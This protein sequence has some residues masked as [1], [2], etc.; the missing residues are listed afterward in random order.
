MLSDLRS[1]NLQLA[2]ISNSDDRLPKVLDQKQ[3]TQYFDLIVTS[4]EC[5]FEKPDKRI[6]EKV[7]KHF[8]VA[9]EEAL[10]VGDDV[11]K[12]FR[13]ARNL[14]MSALIVDANGRMKDKLSEEDQK[15]VRSSLEGLFKKLPV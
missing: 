10:H 13:A 2:V 7:L 15:F 4:H 6:F 5:G 8:G 12:D 1:L 11:E 9:P 14:G 3:L